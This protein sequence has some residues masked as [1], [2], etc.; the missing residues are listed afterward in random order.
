MK[1][2]FPSL[3]VFALLL[4]LGCKEV[5]VLIPDPG[6]GPGPSP[7]TSFVPRRVL[8]EELTGVQCPN[9]PGGATELINLAAA[10]GDTG[11]IIVSI[12]AAQGFTDPFAASQYDFRTIDGN[13]LS[14]YIGSPIG[15]P[16][17]AV[18][19]V[20]VNNRDYLLK[21]QWAAA[22][23][24]QLDTSYQIRVDVQ[25]SYNSASRALH[26]KVDAKSR[27]S[28]QYDLR[29][30]VL[31]TEDSIVDPQQ[32]NLTYVP[33]YLH[34]HVLRDVVTA[35]NGDA[36]GSFDAGEVLTREFDL[37]LPAGWKPEHCSVV[38]FVH[39]GGD[40]DKEVL[41]AAEEH[42]AD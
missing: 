37:T 38:A 26:V 9:C 3:A 8:V 27:F 40:P 35:Y 13:N 2:T 36:I 23:A 7:D 29:L 22:I 20:R 39:R 18:N 32:V 41:Q 24:N 16:S 5:P 28:L 25:N 33:D 11:I 19:R 4:A 15:F 30:T 34:R 14:Q 1:K 6:T 12:H 42:V 10:Y 17:A 31:I 21:Q